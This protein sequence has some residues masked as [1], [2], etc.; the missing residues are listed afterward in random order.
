VAQVGTGAF[1]TLARVAPH[2][3][4]VGAPMGGEIGHVACSVGKHAK[5]QTP[6][7]TAHRAL[8]N[9]VL[10]LERARVAPPHQERGAI[11]KWDGRVAAR[12]SLI[13]RFEEGGMR[14]IVARE[15]RPR[16]DG[17]SS[18]TPSESAAVAHIAR[19][20]TTKETAYALG[21]SDATVRVLLMRAA[22]RCGARSRSDLVRTWSSMQHPV[23][24][25]DQEDQ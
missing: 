2:V 7:L 24:S 19:G 3:P 1:E 22:R 17:K 13:D 16:P 5:R 14:Y 15:D 20:S 6:M 8:K 4:C 25:S 23:P 18:L 10:E 9:A 12:W 21:V 11:E